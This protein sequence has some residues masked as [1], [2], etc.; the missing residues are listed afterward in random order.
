MKTFV[1][2][3]DIPV[4]KTDPQSWILS[5]PKM[6]TDAK[7]T[8]VKLKTVYC[9]TP[10]RKIIAEFEGPDKDSVSKALTTIGMPF[11]AVNE[12]TRISTEMKTFVVH[13][14]VPVGKLDVPEWVL[15]VPK[16]LA[17]A[18]LDNV[19][20]KT[21]YCCTPDRKIIAEFEGPNKDAVSKALNKIGVPFTAMIEVVKVRQLYEESPP[22]SSFDYGHIDR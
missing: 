9:C 10:D 12:T 17:E 15:G 6:L 1:V 3:S 7:L 22:L 14:D 4:L 2:N 11:T 19:R 13:S 16:L 8:N 18:K 20:L 5:I 21:A